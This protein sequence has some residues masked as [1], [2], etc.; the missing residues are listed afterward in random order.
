MYNTISKTKCFARLSALKG[1][2]VKTSELVDGEVY[3]MKYGAG[4][5]RILEICGDD[6]WVE[7]FVSFNTKGRGLVNKNKRSTITTRVE[8]TATAEEKAMLPALL[9]GIEQL[10]QG[11]V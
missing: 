8:R 4:I 10:I 6:V 5:K 9:D 11:V 2:I 1:F 7:W 3:V